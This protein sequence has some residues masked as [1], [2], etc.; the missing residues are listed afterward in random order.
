MPSRQDM[1][2]A[3]WQAYR[4]SIGQPHIPFN[5]E[6][7][8]AQAWME[9]YRDWGSP[10]TEETDIGGGYIVQTFARAVVSWHP[11]HGINVET[12]VG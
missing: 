7:A 3:L 9:S 8:I 10:I 12:G 5:T 4:D 11:D 6:T 2:E 1:F